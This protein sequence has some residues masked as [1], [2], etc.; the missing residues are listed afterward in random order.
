MQNV[1]LTGRVATWLELAVAP[2]WRKARASIKL[3][4]IDGIPESCCALSMDGRWLCTS[5]GRLTVFRGADAAHRFLKSVN[6]NAVEEGES[7]SSAPDYLSNAY[8]L[9]I[10]RNDALRACKLKCRQPCSK[11]LA[12]AA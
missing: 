6:I 1:E 4:V 9:A 5:D 2:E 10:G 12:T 3:H 11:D 7:S 8:C